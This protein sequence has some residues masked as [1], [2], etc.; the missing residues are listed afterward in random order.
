V[1]TALVGNAVDLVAGSNHVIGED[2]GVA[3]EQVQTIRHIVSEVQA[4]LGKH[5]KNGTR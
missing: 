3:K 2:E 4:K 1:V 5:R